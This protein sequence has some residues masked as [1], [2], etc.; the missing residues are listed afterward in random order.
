MSGAMQGAPSQVPHALVTDVP[1]WHSSPAQSWW[2]RDAGSRLSCPECP[3]NVEM[4]A[5]HSRGVP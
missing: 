5:W 2:L 3:G 1:P 4:S